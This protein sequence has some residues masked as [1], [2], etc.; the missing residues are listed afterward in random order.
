[1]VETG[2]EN[3]QIY[4]ALD[5][6][7]SASGQGGSVIATLFDQYNSY[8]LVVATGWLTYLL[9]IGIVNSAKDG[10]AFGRG[11]SGTWGMLRVVGSFTMLAP[12]ASGYPIIISVIMAIAGQAVGMAN[13]LW[14][15][16]VNQMTEHV[17]PISASN[18]LDVTRVA[19]Q[20]WEIQ[21]CRVLI[22]SIFFERYDLEKI[23]EIELILMGEDGQG[24][25][26]LTT[27]PLM[28]DGEEI[29]G[30]NACGSAQIG[31]P[32][33]A[34]EDVSAPAVTAMQNLHAQQ[35]KKIARAAQPMLVN[36]AGMTLNS[37][38]TKWK[39]SSNRT[40]AGKIGG[41]ISEY[42]QLVIAQ[43]AMIA[44]E[45]GDRLRADF[46]DR[47]L[48]SGWAGAGMYW[49]EISKL[50]ARAASG[51]RFL[52]KIVG[53]DW[54]YIIEQFNND[55]H[56]S[57]KVEAFR[58]TINDTWLMVD[59]GTGFS[60]DVNEKERE[61]EWSDM[62]SVEVWSD[63][64]D[65]LKNWFSKYLTQSVRRAQYATLSITNFSA[66]GGSAEDSAEY[67]EAM[68][69]GADPEKL[70]DMMEGGG[71]V[72]PITSLTGFGHILL[73]TSEAIFGGMA[74]AKMILTAAAKSADNLANQPVAG[75]AAAPLSGGLAAA[76]SLHQ[77]LSTYTN[78]MA[79][80]LFLV[81]VYF[82]FVIPFMVWINYLF[83]I[84]QWMIGVVE[85]ILAAPLWMVI[86][87]SFKGDEFVD[88][89]MVPGWL[90]L[91]GVL[92]KPMLIVI[93]FF[94]TIAV[95]YIF[96]SIAMSQF[97]PF[98]NGM[99]AGKVGITATIVMLVFQ[100]V[101]AWYIGKL[102]FRLMTSVPD[103]IFNVWFN[104]QSRGNVEGDVAGALAGTG[105]TQRF[106]GVV[107]AAATMNKTP[108]GR[109]RS[110]GVDIENVNPEGGSLRPNVKD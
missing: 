98:F 68:A 93:G 103:T 106:E 26:Q 82:A 7:T 29:L 108:T 44:D 86:H 58:H 110:A 22:N 73:N 89:R 101:V 102:S 95:Y 9:L 105:I 37:R 2:Y 59:R 80:T 43:A 16:G 54:D 87:M 32:A 53:P 13:D 30:K 38:T 67:R 40:A 61:L 47:A 51:M 1:M 39:D 91:L 24:N 65:S 99:V 60:I 33:I 11:W 56:I 23:N 75:A 85:A 46:K 34:G 64:F 81:G 31:G 96:I 88:N 57:G 48:K 19:Q 35:I 10:E 20:I 3:D 74:G 78:S 6:I 63:G 77:S 18:G 4:R 21:S 27:T 109:V 70:A 15:R 76:V 79:G 97:I 104:I 52:P 83:A 55:D 5:V 17:S 69:N 50:N 62:M 36:I 12:T 72:D 41:T 8:V 94:L 45:E 84:F 25:L 90:I 14:E 42:N 107:A 49:L 92:I 100:V 28:V 71:V 66:E